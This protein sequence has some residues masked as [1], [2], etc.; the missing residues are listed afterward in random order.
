MFLYCHF[1]D[2][3]CMLSSGTT[4][5]MCRSRFVFSWICA[6]NIEELFLI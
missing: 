6:R 5:D 1:G 2:W 3:L 4:A